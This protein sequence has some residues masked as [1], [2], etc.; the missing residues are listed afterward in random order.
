MCCDVLSSGGKREKNV[1]CPPHIDSLRKDPV[2]VSLPHL[3]VEM[4]GFRMGWHQWLKFGAA[5]C[6]S[7]Y[8][9]IYD[10]KGGAFPIYCHDR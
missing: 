2:R 8:R 6:R 5:L 7:I 1:L 4:G 3:N 9:E 10:R